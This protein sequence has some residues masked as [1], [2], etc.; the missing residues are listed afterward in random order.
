MLLEILKSA[1]SLL[2]GFSL[3]SIS[4]PILAEVIATSPP[5]FHFKPRSIVSTPGIPFQE[6]VFPTSGDHLLRG[7]FYPSKNP[8]APAIIYAHA[9]GRDLRSGLSLV[10]PLHKA[11]FSVLLFSYR[12]H[13]GSEGNPFGF[14]YGARESEDVDSAVRYLSDVRSVH[15]IGVI[16][17]SAGAVSVILSAA[18][19]PFIDAVVAASPYPS[20]EEVWE[21]NRPSFIFRPYYRMI[22]KISEFIKGY[23]RTEIRPRDVISEISPRPLLLIHGSLDGR[24][25]TEQAK[26]LYKVANE[27]KQ[28]WILEGTSHAG[29]RNPGLEFLIGDIVDFFNNAFQKPNSTSHEVFLN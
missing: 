23:S 29:V 12:G 20:L 17:H 2:L 15:R 11:G 21:N 3:L 19:N 14:T 6:V 25:T 22:M 16:G 9:T 5:V 10:A 8:D 28:L 13:G 24:I 26:E 27:P 18:R 1:S 4:G 7:W